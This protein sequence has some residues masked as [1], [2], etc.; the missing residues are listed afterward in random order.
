M[1]EGKETKREGRKQNRKQGS[2]FQNSREY[3]KEREIIKGGKIQFSRDDEKVNG[4]G[5]R[6]KG[7]KEKRRKNV[8][9]KKQKKKI[10]Q[11]GEEKWKRKRK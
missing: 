8:K 5:V 6:K 11:N 3:D 1:E 4:K 7:E 9:M 2:S 10:G